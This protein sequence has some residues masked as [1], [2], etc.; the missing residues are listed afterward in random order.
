MS[1]KKPCPR[2]GSHQVA[3]NKIYHKGDAGHAV[4][5]LAHAAHKH[6][7]AAAV[8]GAIWLVGKAVDQVTDDYRCGKCNHTYS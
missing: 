1:A 5:H 3:S 4:G 8:F 7:V 6:P 2:C